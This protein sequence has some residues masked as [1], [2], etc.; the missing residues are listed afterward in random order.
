MVIYSCL[1]RPNASKDYLGYL[2]NRYAGYAPNASDRRTYYDAFGFE[3][4]FAQIPKAATAALLR[5]AGRIRAG[6]TPATIAPGRV[7][8][9]QPRQRNRPIEAGLMNRAG[10]RGLVAR[11]QVGVLWGLA[12]S[13]E[14]TAC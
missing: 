12:S 10:C 8:G 1:R 7:P 9:Y 3:A 14:V 2:I 13:S 5:I 4:I 11:T 6:V